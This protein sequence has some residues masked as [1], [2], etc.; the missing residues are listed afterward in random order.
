MAWASKQMEPGYDLPPLHKGIMTQ[1]K[2][3]AYSRLE[4]EVSIHTDEELA[5]KVGLPG[6]VAAGMMLVDYLSEMLTNF[7]GTGWIQGGKC[8][9]SFILPVRPG[10]EIT[11]R[12]VVRE[13][14]SEGAATRLILDV[15][16]ENQRGEKVTAGTASGLVY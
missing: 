6:T 12:G 10:D 4:A 14:L 1:A 16:C 8:A 13:K 11:A 5:K 9:V 2:M 3:A 15:W 7:F